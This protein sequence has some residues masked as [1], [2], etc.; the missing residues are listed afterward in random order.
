M[1]VKIYIEGV[2]DVIF[3]G[4]YLQEVLGFEGDNNLKDKIHLF[5]TDTTKVQLLALG[6]VS[7]LKD[8]IIQQGI[9]EDFEDGIQTLIILDADNQ[10]N[11]GGFTIRQAAIESIKTNL[12][13]EYFLIPNHQEDGYLET[14]L[15]KIIVTEYLPALQCLKDQDQCLIAFNQNLTTGK[16]MKV[17]PTKS[18]DKA[19]MNSFMGRLKNKGQDRF[20]DT[21]IWNLHHPYLDK[22]KEFLQTNLQIT[23]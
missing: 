22:L 8:D 11:D 7:N 21:T 10:Y 4:T 2:N 16:K 20:K 15:G 6:G 19:V 17:A 3:I 14:L 18:A 13:F 1:E 23:P 5:E 12:P 9:Q